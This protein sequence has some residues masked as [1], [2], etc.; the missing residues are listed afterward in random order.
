[1]F[2]KALTIA[3]SAI[4]LLTINSCEKTLTS[5][6]DESVSTIESSEKQIMSWEEYSSTFVKKYKG[7]YLVENY[8][9]FDSYEEV[10]TFYNTGKVPVNTRGSGYVGSDGFL[11]R[12]TGG[13]E[14]NLSYKVTGF[15]ANQTRVRNLINEAAN[16]W[17]SGTTVNFRDFTTYPIS[18]FFTIKLEENNEIDGVAK[19]FFPNETGKKELILSTELMS[20]SNDSLL[21]IIKHELGHVLGLRHEWY[22]WKDGVLKSEEALLTTEKDGATIMNVGYENMGFQGGNIYTGDGHISDLDYLSVNMLYNKEYGFQQSWGTG[23]MHSR[24]YKSRLLNMDFSGDDKMDLVEAWSNN[25]RIALR[26]FKSDGSSFSKVWSSDNM[27]EGEASYNLVALD[28]N[29]D[30]KDDIIQPWNNNGK[31]NFLVYKSNGTSFSRL[32]GK[33]MN[34]TSSNLGFFAADING[35][36]A[37]E[38]I[39]P[40]SY[41]GRVSF[42][43]YRSNGTSFDTYW[44]RQGFGDV[45]DNSTFHVVDMNGDGSDDIIQCNNSPYSGSVTFSLY[46]SSRGGLSYY[47]RIATISKSDLITYKLGDVDGD[48]RTDLVYVT[49]EGD[50]GVSVNEGNITI[51][52][53][54]SSGTSFLA[55]EERFIRNASHAYVDCALKDVDGDEK[56][57]LTYLWEN[58]GRLAITVFTSNNENKFERTWTTYSMNQGKGSTG[59]FFGDINGDKN[60]DIIQPWDNSGKIGMIN[61]VSKMEQ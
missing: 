11:V 58:K 6:H 23:N 5:V 15:G 20:Q 40:Y 4:C 46:L 2:K 24:G 31:V 56:A 44:S 27:G 30:N 47:G 13:R 18:A 49:K 51:N 39:Q 26:S 61:Y 9:T 37:K 17:E 25:G 35:Y 7:R 38:L 33:T 53:C 29:S 28:I 19:A 60:C 22:W 12:W 54:F 50:I 21:K 43:V 32:S 8:L 41:N 55:P 16:E 14:K 3:A 34:E 48:K 1:M 59:Y 42:N 52:T 10:K 36:G 57:D 45:V